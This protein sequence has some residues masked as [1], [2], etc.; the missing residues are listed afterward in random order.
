[1]KPRLIS[2]FNILF[3]LNARFFGCLMGFL[4]LFSRFLV[5]FLKV[6]VLAYGIFKHKNI[7]LQLLNI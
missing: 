5:T 6:F 7:A 4:R 3:R 2:L 1:M